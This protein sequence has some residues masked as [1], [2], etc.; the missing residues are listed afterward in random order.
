MAPRQYPPF[1]E[2]AIPIAILLIGM[3]ALILLVVIGVVL[4]QN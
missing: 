1:F 3:L 4:S 2:K